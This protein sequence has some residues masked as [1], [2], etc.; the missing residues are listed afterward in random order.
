VL[1]H[2]VPGVPGT[3][4]D[5]L[6]SW[7]GGVCAEITEGPTHS[8]YLC[9]VPGCV[10]SKPSKI[11]WK[12]KGI[13]ALT[14]GKKKPANCESH[15]TS[16]YHYRNMLKAKGLFESEEDTK[17]LYQTRIQ[18]FHKKASRWSRTSDGAKRSRLV[19]LKMYREIA[20]PKHKSLDTP[21][22]SR[23]D[24]MAVNSQNT[25]TGSTDGIT[26]PRGPVLPNITVATAVSAGR[27]TRNHSWS[28]PTQP[29]TTVLLNGLRAQTSCNQGLVNRSK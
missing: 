20:H 22:C 6:I 10:N 4:F 24:P 17:L 2:A 27:P 12:G 18:P 3:L 1:E 14:A 16:Y 26:V 21:V 19:N 15:L 23:T 28:A 7:N 9:K 11:A 5:D 25:P 8:A 29:S 13:F